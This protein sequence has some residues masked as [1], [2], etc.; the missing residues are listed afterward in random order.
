M[1]SWTGAALAN[2]ARL[3]IYCQ[4]GLQF[5]QIK[6]HVLNPSI[7]RNIGFYRVTVVGF[8]PVCYIE[9]WF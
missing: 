1:P 9:F 4:E 2:T 6:M 5:A 3:K 8:W 7:E